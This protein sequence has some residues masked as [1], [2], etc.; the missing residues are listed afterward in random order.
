MTETSS[1]WKTTKVEPQLHQEMKTEAALR[2]MSLN[3]LI[4]MVLTEWLV[5]NRHQITPANGDPSL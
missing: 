2:A 3:D 1:G 5:K 4:H